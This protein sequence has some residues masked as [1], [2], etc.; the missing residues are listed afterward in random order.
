VRS[1]SIPAGRYV[2]L[3][4]AKRQRHVFDE[5]DH[6][7]FETAI[8]VALREGK[9]PQVR[10][11][12]FEANDRGGSEASLRRVDDEQVVLAEDRERKAADIVDVQKP[13]DLG[14]IVP[15]RQSDRK[16]EAHECVLVHA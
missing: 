4:T 6:A 15:V 2:D 11:R 14:R 8:L 10:A 3:R 13:R 1:R 9:T 7:V 12:L 5:L 16:V